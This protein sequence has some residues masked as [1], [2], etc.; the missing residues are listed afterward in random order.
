MAAG[1]D[2]AEAALFLLGSPTLPDG[3]TQTEQRTEAVFVSLC[4]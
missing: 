4:H 3:S 1:G 2:P